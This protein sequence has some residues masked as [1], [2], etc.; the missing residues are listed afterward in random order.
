MAKQSDDKSGDCHN[1]I[2]IWLDIDN[3]LI[4]HGVIL[5]YELQCHGKGRFRLLNMNGFTFQEILLA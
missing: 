3:S 1:D 5:V 2:G 4:R